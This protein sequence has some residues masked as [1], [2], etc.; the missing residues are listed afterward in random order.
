MHE[1]SIV[2]SV[3]ACLCVCVCLFL[4]ERERERQRERERVQRSASL[5]TFLG[6]FFSKNKNVKSTFGSVGKKT[7]REKYPPS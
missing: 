7:Y 1:T 5:S 2:S 4:E 3:F 6:S